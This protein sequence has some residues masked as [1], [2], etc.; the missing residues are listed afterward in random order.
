MPVD[1]GVTTEAATERPLHDY[2]TV[3]GGTSGT[4]LLA[5]PVRRPQIRSADGAVRPAAGHADGSAA[6]GDPGDWAALTGVN[7][8]VLASPPA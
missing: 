2:L 3:P 6:A 8:T 4:S 1:I 7:G 5:V